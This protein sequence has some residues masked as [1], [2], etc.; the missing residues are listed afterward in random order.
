MRNGRKI[1]L[2]EISSFL[3][4]SLFVKLEEDGNSPLEP[5]TKAYTKPVKSGMDEARVIAISV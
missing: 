3:I 4:V 2:E 1:I 5:G